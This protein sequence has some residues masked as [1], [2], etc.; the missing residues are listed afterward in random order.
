MFAWFKGLRSQI[1]R[2]LPERVS[3]GCEF[4]ATDKELDEKRRELTRLMADFARANQSEDVRCADCSRYAWS[5][6]AP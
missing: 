4:V 3:S 5:I 1:S 6:G 2:G